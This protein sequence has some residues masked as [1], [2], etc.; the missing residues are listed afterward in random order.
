M[1]MI[2]FS[3][4]LL[5]FAINNNTSQDCC[6]NSAKYAYKNNERLTLSGFSSLNELKFNCSKPFY[7]SI[8]QFKPSKQLILDD[9][10]KFKNF[11]VIPSRNYFLIMLTNFKGF[12]LN[13]Y[14]FDEFNDLDY[15]RENLMISIDESNFDF[16]LNRTLIRNSE[17]NQFLHVNSLIKNVINLIIEK[18]TQFSEETC[19]FSFKNA[20]IQFFQINRLTSSFIQKN[21][22]IFQ[23]VSMN[24]INCYIYSANLIFYHADFNTR[25]LNEHVFKN[26]TLLQINGIISS[27]QSDIFKR[28]NQIRVIRIHSQNI[29]NLFSR[30][31]NWLKYLNY[32][33]DLPLRLKKPL[34]LV[35]YQSLA[36]NTFYDY[37]EKDICFFKD[38]PHENFVLPILRPAEKSQ[39]S[40]TEIYLVQYTT[41]FKNIMSKYF[42]YGRVSYYFVSQF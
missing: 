5:A 13:S 19:P 18:S 33:T 21:M 25:L 9:S 36:N 1:I 15:F 31:N 20:R 4:L 6:L 38:F 41:N 39:C 32:Q 14:P 7:L 17:C 34:I 10:L 8:L 28:F 11:I 12:D 35:L 27:I 3:I 23:N 24:S 37:S 29:K 2:F 30:N 22:L 26:I 42:E 40:C 16:Y